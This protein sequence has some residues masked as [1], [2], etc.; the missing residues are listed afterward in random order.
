MNAQHENNFKTQFF[1]SAPK[2]SDSLIYH[3]CQ[4]IVRDFALCIY[5]PP[6]KEMQSSAVRFGNRV[7]RKLETRLPPN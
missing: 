1:V 7:S 6:R 4:H 5:Y 3:M 2:K